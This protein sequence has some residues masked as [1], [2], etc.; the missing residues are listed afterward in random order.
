MAFYIPVPTGISSEARS[1]QVFLKLDSL[2]NP[3]IP[4]KKNSHISFVVSVINLMF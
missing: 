2:S 1:K 4:Y 3:H